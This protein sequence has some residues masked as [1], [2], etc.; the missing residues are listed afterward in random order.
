[1]RTMT[2]TV[3]AER[4]RPSRALRAAARSA[5]LLVVT[6]RALGELADELGGYEAAVR[7]L[8]TVATTVGR[9]IGVNVP[10]GPDSSRSVFVPPK[11][12]GE[13][14]LA[15]WAAGKRDELE[16]AFGP[17]SVVREDE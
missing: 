5:P 9:P 4:V 10:T 8:V 13:E 3:D 11:G 7:F 15:G 6:G 2:V 1:M 12:W 17:A 14:R 16:A